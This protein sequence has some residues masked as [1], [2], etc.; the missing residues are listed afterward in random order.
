MALKALG[1]EGMG[2]SSAPTE[3]NNAHL[4][5]LCLIQLS[6]LESSLYQEFLLVG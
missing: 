5:L 2:F 6:S 3:N 4:C 1:V